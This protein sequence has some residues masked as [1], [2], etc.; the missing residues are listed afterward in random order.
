MPI[1]S[2]LL[3]NSLGVLRRCSGRTDGFGYHWG[4]SV[5]A[6]ALEAFRTIFQRPARGR[7]RVF[8]PHL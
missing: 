6:E 8:E 5:H 7:S 1:H 3:K 2:R 4:F